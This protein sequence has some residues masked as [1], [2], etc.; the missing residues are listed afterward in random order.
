MPALA[1]FAP[2]CAHL[3]DAEFVAAFENCTLRSEWFHHPDHIRLAWLYLRDCGYGVAERRFREGLIRLAGHFG[4]ARKFHLTITLAWLRA[5]AARVTIGDATPF[6][7]WMENHSELL[8]RRFLLNHYSEHRLATSEA[9]TGWLE[10]DRVAL[11]LPAAQDATRPF[12][13][14]SAPH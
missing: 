3:S 9:R 1:D 7:L 5:V 13:A 10:P 4:V 8:D 6:E 11:P 2:G 14:A 12:A